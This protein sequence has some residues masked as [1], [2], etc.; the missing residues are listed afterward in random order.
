MNSRMIFHYAKPII[1]DGSSGTSV[2]P[3]MMLAA[4]RS[5]GF[6]VDV[7]GGFR[8]EREKAISCVI[9][10][11]LND[12]IYS[13]AYAESLTTPT[14]I[15]ERG[16]SRSDIHSRIRFAKWALQGGSGM[17]FMF[18][19]WLRTYSIP[20]GL[21]YRDV[22]WRFEHY[23]ISSNRLKQAL[24]SYLFKVEWRNYQKSIDHLFVPTLEMQEILPSSW[25]KKK[26]SSLPPGCIP[27]KRM[28]TDSKK[29]SSVLKLLCWRNHA[30]NI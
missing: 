3:G 30:P 1:G 7:I 29:G 4:F 26:I 24:H 28:R 13:F 10:N 2:R 17:D 12:E 11:V 27:N 22:H 18:F 25:D 9:N 5:L 14:L 20:V 8:Q 19:R 6:E 16:N 23:R 15:V 21:F